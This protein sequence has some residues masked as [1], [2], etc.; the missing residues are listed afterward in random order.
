MPLDQHL[1][2]WLATAAKPRLRPRS[3]LDY[4]SLL[5]LHVR[6]VLGARPVGSITRF[7]IQSLYAGMLQRGLSA[8]TIEYRTKQPQGS[9]QYCWVISMTVA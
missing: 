7:D 1:D 6:P 9:R 5:R 2:R 4:E 8:R 3:N